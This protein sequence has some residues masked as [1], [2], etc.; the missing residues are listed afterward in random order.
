[1]CKNFVFEL[2]DVG[3]QEMK[4]ILIEQIYDEILIIYEIKI[5]IIY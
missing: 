4:I 5:E 1:M 2:C 3:F